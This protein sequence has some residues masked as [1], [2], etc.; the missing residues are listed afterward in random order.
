MGSFYDELFVLKNLVRTGWTIRFGENSF[1]LESDAEHVFSC[2]ML[3]LKIIH[4]EKL[5]I[6]VEKVLKMILYHEI[7]EID[8]GDIPVIDTERRKNKYELERRGVERIAKENNFDEILRL[9]EEF[10]ENATQEAKF[11]KMIDKMDTVI[12]AKKYAIQTNRPE[13]FEEFKEN[14]MPYIKGYEKYLDL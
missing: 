7:G 3:A 2:A 14:A 10:E 6:N 9:W 4:D 1:R 13:V 5:E 8:V 11:C 12:Q